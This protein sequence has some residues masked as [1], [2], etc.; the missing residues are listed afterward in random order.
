[1]D[2]INTRLSNKNFSDRAPKE[3][4]EQEKTNFNNLE[5]DAKKLQLT[6]EN[7]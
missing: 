4:I 1:M 7:L 6:L 5:K 2:K 3:I